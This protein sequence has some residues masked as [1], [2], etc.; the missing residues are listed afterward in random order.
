MAEFNPNAYGPVIAELIAEDRLNPLDGNAHRKG[1]QC[2]RVKGD[3]LD[4]ECNLL[5]LKINP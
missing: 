2:A 3:H 1:D 4:Q 5:G